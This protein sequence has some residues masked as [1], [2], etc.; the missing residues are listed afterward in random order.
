MLDAQSSSMDAGAEGAYQWLTTTSHDFDSLL[1]LCP[2]TA[3]GKY[4]AVTSFDSRSL[5][6]SHRAKVAGWENR[7]GI[8]YSPLIQSIGTLPPSREELNHMLNLPQ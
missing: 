7:S 8:A 6:L 3:L 4:V 1:A 5:D 2:T